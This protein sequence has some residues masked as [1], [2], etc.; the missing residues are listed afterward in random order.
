VVTS[1]EPIAFAHMSFT[2][3]ELA[4]EGREKCMFIIRKM[5]TNLNLFVKT[6]GCVKVLISGADAPVLKFSFMII[7]MSDAEWISA[8]EDGNDDESP[9]LGT[10]E[11]QL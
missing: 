10:L 4:S 6:A 7:E 5:V 9:Y 1:D 3:D 11:P 8:G 2:K